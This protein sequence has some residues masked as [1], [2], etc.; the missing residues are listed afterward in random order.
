MAVLKNVLDP[1]SRL[2]NDVGMTASSALLRP[3]SPDDAAALLAAAQESP[4]LDRQLPRMPQNLAES[5]QIIRAG[6]MPATD[7]EHQ[8]KPGEPAEHSGLRDPC[9]RGSPE[10]S[11]LSS[12]N[13]A[14]DLD[15]R[16]IGNVGISA[17]ERT[18]DT[19]WVHYWITASA[20]GQGVT[21]RAVATAA[22]WALAPLPHGLG[23]YRLE[24]GHRR[25]NP[26]SRAVAIGAGFVPEGIERAKLRYVV[27][28]D[29]RSA[30]KPTT[31]RTERFDVETHARLLTDPAP[32]VELLHLSVPGSPA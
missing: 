17:I 15:G 26:A 21:T 30:T 23:L 6:L 4:D 7:L 27:T 9:D 28:P 11:Q 19:G 22:R 20:R 13:L 8:V 32:D 18:H 3:W 10:L 31:L 29:G 5:E 25:N 1:R 24:L 2:S 16:A 12:V 14:I